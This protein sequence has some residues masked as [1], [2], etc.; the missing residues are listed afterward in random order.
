MRNLNSFNPKREARPSQ[1]HAHGSGVS[2]PELFQSQT[3]SQALSDHVKGLIFHRLEV[4]FNPKREARPSQTMSSVLP[5]KIFLRKFQSQT[6]SQALSDCS[7]DFVTA[8]A[9]MFQ[10]QTGSQALSDKG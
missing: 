1:T 4:G 3:G 9:G 7:T 6:G 8:A 5:L 2:V 10:S